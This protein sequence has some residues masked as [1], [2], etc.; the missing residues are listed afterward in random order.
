M[1]LWTAGEAVTA[2]GG[3]ATG[4]WAAEGVSIDTR[5]LRPGD[6]FV[7]LSAARDGH[8]FVA[9]ALD[10]GA[11]A[12][13][14]SR[15]PEGVAADAPLLV[16]P[17]VLRGLEDLGR[18]ARARTGARVV[19]VTGSVGKTSTKEMLRA[20][21]ATQG[22]VHA[23]EASY[24]NH[25]GVPL[26][27]ARMPADA[28]WAVIEIGMNH[29]GEIAPLAQQ[30]RP[31]VALVTTVG[32]AHLEAFGSLDGIAEEKGSVCEG[33]EPGGVAVLPA[34]APQLPILRACAAK[35]GARVVT[36]GMAAGAH[37]RLLD[38]Q[39]TAGATVGRARV[40]RTPIHVKVATEGRHFALNALGALAAVQALGGDRALALN[41]LA[42]WAPPKGRGGR[43]TVAWG[44]GTV[45]LIDDA[46]NA[47][48]AS[49]AAGLAVLAGLEPED[50]T[51]RIRRGRR[52]AILGDML[53]LGAGEAALHAGLADDPAMEAVHVVHCVGPRMR[54]LHEALPGDK[55]GERAETPEAL[56]AGLRRL[57]DAGDIVLVKGS[58]GSRVS[59]VVDAIRRM[60]QGAPSNEGG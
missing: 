14:V 30:A 19:A 12:A 49:M 33:L 16:V 26:T 36:F 40:W 37:H 52:I 35:A 21:L 39:V 29:P 48:P 4:G 8:E 34:D 17:D 5:T 15:I 3:T 51:G 60:G 7:A 47:N 31:H 10:K 6:L 50:G 38:A 46:F 59:V 55:R 57:L 24:N 41:G 27:L 22:K 25:W 42:A 58:K 56:A 1:S 53:E 13:L 18:A 32:A 43:E 28:R 9:Q 23:A 2:T 44:D 20:A 45:T 11:A 54:A